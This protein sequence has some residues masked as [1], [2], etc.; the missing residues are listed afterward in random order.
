MDAVRPIRIC[1]TTLRDGEQAPGVSFTMQEKL[2]IATLLNA[3][4]VHAIEAGIPAMGIG[5][6]E[7][8]RQITA[9]GLEAEIVGWCRANRLD[10]YAAA[11]CGMRSVHLTIPVS[12]LH[13]VRKLGRDRRWAER[14]IE[15]CVRDALDRGLRVSVGFEDASRADDGFVA[16][17]AARVTR[18]GVRRLRWADTVG[19]LEPFDGYARLARLAGAVPGVWEIHAHDDFGLATA[20]SLAAVR[21][22]FTWVSTTVAGLGERAGNAPLEEV[23]MGLRHLYGMDPGLDTTRFRVLACLV[24]R[25]ARRP[26]PAG[27]A[28]VGNSVFTHESGIHVDGVLKA[29][30]TYEPFDPAEV[31]GR[32][33]L[34]VGKHSG[35]SSLRRVLAQYGIAADEQHLGVLLERI[36]AKTSERK[37]PLRSAEVRDLFQTA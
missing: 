30:A 13:L 24:A 27:K 5:E 9:A 36:R 31:G 35:R 23:V 32:R 4:G 28:V 6:Q 34:L 26:L 25:A 1:D 22:G 37:R 3:C 7:A 29:A 16:E 18:L 2:A 17:L 21:A 14:H 20:N 11:K 19:V 12:D 10:I 15:D 8:L 33:R